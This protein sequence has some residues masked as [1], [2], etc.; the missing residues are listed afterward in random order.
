MHKLIRLGLITTVTFC[1]AATAAPPLHKPLLKRF[2]F[3]FKDVTAQETKDDNQLKACTRPNSPDIAIC[4]Q[5]GET[6]AGVSGFLSGLFYEYYKGRLA[7]VT[8]TFLNGQGNF[9]TVNVALRAKYGAPCAITHAR[10][11]T[12]RGIVLDN[13]NFVWC[14]STGKLTLKK[15][16]TTRDVSR[17]EY[18][19][20]ILPVENVVPPKDF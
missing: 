2:V 1:G 6:V 10:W 7:G 4:V 18:A 3:K 12:N 19:D 14:F 16:V 13:P 8:F 9:D 17:L 15:Y 11:E 5:P 20:V